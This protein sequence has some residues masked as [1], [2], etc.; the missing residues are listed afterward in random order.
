MLTARQ[1]LA[2]C[3]KKDGHPDRFVNQYEPFV[4]LSTPHALHET[5]PVKGGPDVVNS[6]GVT[7]SFPANVP[8]AFP[9][10]T[11][12]KVVIKDIEEWQKYVKAPTLD[13]PESEWEMFQAKYEAVDRTKSYAT[14][15]VAPG[16]FEQTHHLQGIDN[17]LINYMLYPDE[18]HDLLKYLTDYELRLAE[19]TCEKL[20]PDAVFH[21]DD[22]GS[23][24]NSFF[25][26]EMFEEFFLEPYQQIYGYYKSHGCELAIHHSDAY[27][28]N[29]V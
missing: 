15:M 18:M 19:L 16:L 28:A 12:D 13:F 3:L 1:N 4:L 9:V 17:A 11:P 7:R 14:L 26:P 21:H 5:N 8:G 24:T 22:W 29:I 10:H 6:W 20:H 25:R 27:G 2:E 23:E